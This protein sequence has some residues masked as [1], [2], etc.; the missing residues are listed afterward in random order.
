VYVKKD[1]YFVKRNLTY[2]G[3]RLHLLEDA[4]AA[5]GQQLQ[6]GEEDPMGLER[7]VM[8]ADFTTPN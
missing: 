8:H 2:Q 7:S 4:T 1:Y 6:S 3:R 5:I